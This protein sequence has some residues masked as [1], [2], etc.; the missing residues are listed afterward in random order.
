M[1]V[2]Q[3]QRKVLDEPVS[4]ASAMAP[5]EEVLPGPEGGGGALN[6]QFATALFF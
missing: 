3:G 2:A 5:A 6:Q 1:K 4:A